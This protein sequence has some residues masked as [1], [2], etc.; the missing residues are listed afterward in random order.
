M[1][2]TRSRAKMIHNNSSERRA[3]M[4]CFPLY[5]QS[6]ARIDFRFDSCV[7]DKVWRQRRLRVPLLH[8]P[9]VYNK[10]YFPTCTADKRKVTSGVSGEGVGKGC[11]FLFHPCTGCPTEIYTLA[12]PPVLMKIIK[13]SPFFF[14]KWL[15]SI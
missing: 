2:K 11:N 15:T 12:I 8:V 4:R 9:D 3:G 14:V 13:F 10:L 5:I 1:S 7:R 6:S